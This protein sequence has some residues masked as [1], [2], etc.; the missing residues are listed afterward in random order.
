MSTSF[1]GSISLPACQT[2]MASFQCLRR[3]FLLKLKMFLS[4]FFSS[5]VHHVLNSHPFMLEMDTGRMCVFYHPAF[6]L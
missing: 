5:Q 6:L 1:R 4:I 3:N 2:R